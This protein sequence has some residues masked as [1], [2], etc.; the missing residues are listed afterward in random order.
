MGPVNSQLAMITIIPAAYMS[1]RLAIPT[2]PYSFLETDPILIPC[3]LGREHLTFIFCF[4]LIYHKGLFSPY[5]PQNKN[6]ENP[7]MNT[8]SILATKNVFYGLLLS[9]KDL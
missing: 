7:D 6:K 9:S 5:L 8:Y 3:F 2:S 1:Q 4:P